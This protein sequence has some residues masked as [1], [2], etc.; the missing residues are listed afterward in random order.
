MS[1]RSLKTTITGRKTGSESSIAEPAE[2]VTRQPTRPR[3]EHE[4]TYIRVQARRE[5]SQSFTS[6]VLRL[7]RRL[8]VLIAAIY[9]VVVAC[10]GFVASFHALVGKQL[11]LVSLIAY[12]TQAI[13]LI[14]GTSTVQDS[15][16]VSDLLRDDLTPRNDT[17]F[18]DLPSPNIKT[19][20]ASFSSC[21]STLPL[22]VDAIYKNEFL[23][24]VFTALVRDTSY[25][26]TMLAPDR[27]QLVMPVVD[28]S[29]SAIIFED[30]TAAKFF[31]L[32]RVRDKTSDPWVAALLVVTVSNQGYSVVS[33]SE[34]G[35]TSVMTLALVRHMRDDL[36]DT[37]GVQH[38]FALSIGY[39]FEQLRFQVYDKLGTNEENFWILR[40]IPPDPTIQAPKELL[41][42]CRNGVFM[43]AETEQSNVNN[44]L[45]HL[46]A[47][48]TKVVTLIEWYGAP[49]VRDSWAWVHFFHIVLAG[50]A[51]FNVCVLL[52]VSFRNVMRVGTYW[53]GDSFV[54]V[55]TSLVWRGLLVVLSWVLNKAWALREFGL[56]DGSLLSSAPD[57]FCYE[58]IMH[59]DLITIYL[60]IV[61]L[62]GKLLK[63]R[64]DPALSVIC[65]EIGFVMRRSIIKW[66]PAL[67]Q[68]FLDV[69]MSDFL[70]GSVVSD[71]GANAVSPMMLWGIHQALPLTAS[72]VAATLV[73]ALSTIVVLIAIVLVQKLVAHY[74]D[75][76]TWRVKRAIPWKTTVHAVQINPSEPS[77][78]DHDR[79]EPSTGTSTATISPRTQFEIA[80]GA[81]LANQFGLVCDYDNYVFIKGL[82]FASADGIYSNGFVIANGKFLVQIDDLTTIFFMKLF[83]VRFRN[84]YAYDVDGYSVQEM[85][86]L[87]YPDTLS[88]RDLFSLS[89]HILT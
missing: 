84:V 47:Q 80:T 83:R 23:R 79:I 32:T 30:A 29:S 46:R 6:R 53:I 13:P 1:T 57:Y 54:A 60:S 16:L 44:L 4:S 72:F 71:D 56:Y 88:Y 87:V 69:S 49:V 77:F 70:A 67:Y 78:G 58:E 55:S 2:R 15:A 85:A 37:D 45:W 62:I 51:L 9:Y 86:R 33:R 34:T 38:A 68:S 3:S 8:V 48:P 75:I 31:F 59:A 7:V 66:F 50:Q 81:T 61:G 28:C 42:A 27:M 36:A 11:S 65:F 74:K 22:S 82:R 24:K 43:K 39:P 73:P 5:Q 63:A 76:L 25:N 21:P 12:E 18:V 17:L 40:S 26:L 52:L 41:T 64:I 10:R 20:V 35:S 89:I 19:P 14:L